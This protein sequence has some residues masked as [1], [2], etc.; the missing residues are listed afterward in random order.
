MDGWMDGQMNLS[1]LV[2]FF[3][4]FFPTY[5]VSLSEIPISHTLG[6]LDRSSKSMHKGKKVEMTWRA[7]SREQKGELELQEA[8]LIFSWKD[9]QI[10]K[11]MKYFRTSCKGPR[12]PAPECSP[13]HPSCPLGPLDRPPRSDQSCP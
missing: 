2:I 10:A 11:A 13:C 9:M 3:D 8:G 5:S 12:V 6:L 7:R 4:N 1:V